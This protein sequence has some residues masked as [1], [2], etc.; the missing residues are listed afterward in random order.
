[1]KSER[2]LIVVSA[3]SGAGKTTLCEEAVRRLPRLVH[4]VSYTTRP[5]RPDESDGRDY[6]FVEEGTFKRMVAEGAFAEWATV[7]GHLYGTSRKDLEAHFARGNDVILDI[8]TQG[9]AILRAAYPE[10]VFIF[11]LPPSFA[12]LEARLRARG[13]D[14]PEEIARRLARARTEMAAYPEYEYVVVNDDVERAVEV[15]C[16]IITAER[17]KSRRFTPAPDMAPGR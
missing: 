12:Q 13:T 8:D 11:I 17:S 4:S 5:P 7:H 14:R 9:A 16:A 3:P 2:L 15:L 10:G 1:V 6:H